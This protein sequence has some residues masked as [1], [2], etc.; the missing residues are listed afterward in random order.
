MISESIFKY[1]QMI[2]AYINGRDKVQMIWEQSYT[3]S[4]LKIAGY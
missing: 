2:G 3:N 4:R 1:I